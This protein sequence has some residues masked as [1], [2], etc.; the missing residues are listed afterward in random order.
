MSIKF[1]VILE[2]TDTRRNKTRPRYRPR[3]AFAG[4]SITEKLCL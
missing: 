2:S 1:K 4:Q 3:R